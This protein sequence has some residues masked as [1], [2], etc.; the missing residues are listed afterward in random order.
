MCLKNKDNC[1]NYVVFTA[2][3]GKEYPCCVV[4]MREPNDILCKTCECFVSL[5]GTP[6]ERE[7]REKE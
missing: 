1:L 7:H 6:C 4:I 3:S 5:D 2:E